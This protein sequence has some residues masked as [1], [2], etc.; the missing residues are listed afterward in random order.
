MKSAGHPPVAH[1]LH[2]KKPGR[3]SHSYHHHHH[4]HQHSRSSILH[5]DLLGAPR[6]PS[7]LKAEQREDKA[8]MAASFLQ[9]WYVSIVCCSSVVVFGYRGF[10]RGFLSSICCEAAFMSDSRDIVSL[11]ML[12]RATNPTQHRIHSFI[13]YQCEYHHANDGRLCVQ[14]HVRETDCRSQQHGSLL[15]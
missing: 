11:D 1:S 14:R 12:G 10:L 2:H 15:Q 5:P 9:F 13:L 6:T 3:S 4:H 7:K 8:D